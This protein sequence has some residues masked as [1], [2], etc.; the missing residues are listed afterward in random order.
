[1]KKTV[2]IPLVALWVLAT[3]TAALA[4]GDKL[5]HLS[6]IHRLQGRST[7]TTVLLF[8]RPG[9]LLENA[10]DLHLEKPFREEGFTLLLAKTDRELALAIQS[11]VADAIVA[12]IADTSALEHVNSKTPLLIVPVFAKGDKPSEIDAKRFPAAIKSPTNS[13][14]FLDALDQAFE[15]KLARQNAKLQQ[16]RRSN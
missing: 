8:S 5:L 6:R 10:A 1:M 2:A 4:C 11:G 12:D 3:V 14:K 13:G 9:S 7:N 16:V 15:S